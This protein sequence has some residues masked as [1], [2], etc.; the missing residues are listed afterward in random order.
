MMGWK[1]KST[2]SLQICF[3]FPNIFHLSSFECTDV[4]PADAE[5]SLYPRMF[6]WAWHGTKRKTPLKDLSVCTE[7][8]R[9]YKEATISTIQGQD[10]CLRTLEE[11]GRTWP[12]LEPRPGEAIC[13]ACASWPDE[14]GRAGLRS[15]PQ[16]S[17]RR[18]E[19]SNKNTEVGIPTR[20]V[21]GGAMIHKP[22]I[23]AL[24]KCS[25]DLLL[26]PKQNRHQSTWREPGLPWCWIQ[27]SLSWVAP[28]FPWLVM[29]SS[30][31]LVYSWGCN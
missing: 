6:L 22:E 24:R 14:G 10:R 27:A 11:T 5:A 2:N 4:E 20:F 29:E 25:T 9:R 3:F 28:V 13:N 12:W 16:W 1:R 21:P 23:W 15:D 18:L 7:G 26:L 17:R 31:F 19:D 8:Y 30:L